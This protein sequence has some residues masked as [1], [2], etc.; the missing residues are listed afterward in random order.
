MSD[1]YQ[2]LATYFTTE[3]T[4]DVDAIMA[5]YAPDAVFTTPDAV[6][7]GHE[8][9]REFYLD[10]CARFP[11]LDVQV[12]GFGVGENAA[13]EWSAVLTDTDGT[14]LPLRG[15]NVARIV[16]GLIVEMRAYYDTGS[17]N[18]D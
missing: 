8:E 18:A 1:S 11:K 17:Y 10:S 6:R 13:A 4:R 2:T 16:D 5:R 3:M 9:I 7:R 15:A 14:A 12:V